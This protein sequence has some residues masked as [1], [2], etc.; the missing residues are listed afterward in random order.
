MN[1][2]DSLD[3]SLIVNSFKVCGLTT[4]GDRWEY[5]LIHAVKQ[6]DLCDEINRRRNECHVCDIEDDVCSSKDDE[7]LTDSDVNSSLENDD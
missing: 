3:K 1:A 4:K 2:W 5:D 6:L 7:S